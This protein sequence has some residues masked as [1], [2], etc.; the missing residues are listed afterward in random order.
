M[1]D[2]GKRYAREIETRTGS[3]RRSATGSGTLAVPDGLDSGIHIR[4]SATSSKGVCLTGIR[5][6]IGWFL[7]V[8]GDGLQVSVEV[9]LGC[10]ATQRALA[11]SVVVLQYVFGN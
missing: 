8:K 2:V 11:G 6:G 7:L 3:E 1:Y 9:V 10:G 5:C 4:F